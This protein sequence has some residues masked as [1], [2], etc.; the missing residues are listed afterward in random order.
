M[1]IIST[2]IF[3]IFATTTLYAQ[4]KSVV[5]ADTTNN[6]IKEKTLGLNEVVVTATR[7]PKSLKSVPITTRLITSDEIKKS[8]ATNIQDLLTE[9]LPGL[10]FG[11]AMSQET[12]LSMNGFGGSA[13]L[14]LVDGERLAGETMDNVDYNR[15]NLDNIGRIEIVKGAASALYGAN[16]VGGVVNLI[17]REYTDPWH[18][19][20]NSRYRHPGNEWRIGGEAS[21]NTHKWNSNT[22]AQ[23]SRV[24]TIKLADAFDTQSRIHEIFGGEVLNVKEKITYHI[25]ND[26]KLIARGSYFDRVSTRSNYDDHYNDYSGGLRSTMNLNGRNYLEFSY[27]YDQYDK[28]RFIGGKRTHDHDYSNRQHTIRSLYSKF[29]DKYAFT[30]GADMIHDWLMTYQFVNGETPS[31]TNIDAF[32]QFDWNPASWLN[33]I[34][35]VRYDYFSGSH[36]NAVTG[37]FAIMFKLKPATIRTSYAGGF[38]APTL[39]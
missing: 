31:Q 19:N 5:V 37:R 27:G 18:L 2:V 15:L 38:R 16:A 34:G 25:T 35:A 11:Y 29:W 8:D 14:F 28:A 10:E 3:L 22:T 6:D 39:K 12:T 17:S 36:A 26:I 24:S 1:R 33:L 32:A 23:W 13:I 21:F 30:A 7:T 20:V 9:E 4:N